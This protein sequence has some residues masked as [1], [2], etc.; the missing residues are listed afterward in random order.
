MP[1]CLAP[2][3]IFALGED[4]PWKSEASSAYVPLATTSGPKHAR[5]LPKKAS[6]PA[7]A[8]EPDGVSSQTLQKLSTR[9]AALEATSAPKSTVTFDATAEAPPMPPSVPDVPLVT[10]IS[11]SGRAVRALPKE[12]T[13]SAPPT[14]E[15]WVLVEPVAVAE[16]P[17]V[18]PEVAAM[19]AGAVA[20][21]VKAVKAAPA[22]KTPTGGISKSDFVELKSLAAP[23]QV[24]IDVMAA[25]RC[26]LAPA[27]SD[28]KKLDPSWKATK[29]AMTPDFKMKLMEACDKGSIPAA[30]IAKA[31]KLTAGAEPAAVK[32]MSVAAA[33]VCSWVVKACA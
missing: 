26:L 33:A 23:P 27:G 30:N 17:K 6:A 29:K 8:D 13:A 1:L 28:L 19:V 21:A 5:G 4:V 9:V 12:S 7:A 25:A 31:R 3:N 11:S 18:E 10:K 22:K 32:R 24:V 14:E 15:E 16:A 2:S 20:T